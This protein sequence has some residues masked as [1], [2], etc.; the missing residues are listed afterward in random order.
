MTGAGILDR[1]ITVQRATV[2]RNDLNEAIE[3]WTTLASIWANRKDVSANEA[4]RASEVGAEITTRFTVRWSTTTA[5]ITPTD[6]ISYGGRI[7]NITQAR[8]KVGT[9]NR[10]LEIDAV[11]RSDEPMTDETSP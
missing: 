9:R 3:T 11:A 2:E 5:T 1:R 8:E 4:W 10:W 6:R 7:Y